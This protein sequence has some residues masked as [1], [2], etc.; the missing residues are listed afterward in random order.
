MGKIYGGWDWGGRETYRVTSAEF[1][2]CA[3]YGSAALGSV[4]RTLASDHSLASCPGATG[5]ASDF[6]DG[7]PVVHD[8]LVCFVEIEIWYMR[9]DRYQVLFAC[10]L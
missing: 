5:L 4:E 3:N 7:I 8:V 10:V 9:E 2:L 1:L 6:R